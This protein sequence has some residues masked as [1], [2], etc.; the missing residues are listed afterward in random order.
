[1]GHAAWARQ[2]IDIYVQ[3]CAYNT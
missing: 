1:V 2:M 3:C